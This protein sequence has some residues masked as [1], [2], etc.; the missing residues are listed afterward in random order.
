MLQFPLSIAD[1]S[2]IDD[3]VRF[4]SSVVKRSLNH[5]LELKRNET[6]TIQNKSFARRIPL[7][8]RNA[9]TLLRTL[10]A[11]TGWQYMPFSP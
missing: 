1:W 11:T 2:M 7:P 4:A 9:D 10:Y 8:S 5:P 6:S 3:Q